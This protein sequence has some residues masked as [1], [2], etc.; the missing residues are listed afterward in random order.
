MPEK[1]SMIHHVVTIKAAIREA[2][3][4]GYVVGINN[5]C[6]GCGTMSL[7]IGP[8]VN[9]WGTDAAIVIEGDRK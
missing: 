2:E 6:C 5:E 8:D 1:K 4:D 9:A 3:Q 7:E